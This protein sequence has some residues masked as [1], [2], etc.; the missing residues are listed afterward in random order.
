MNL[1]IVQAAQHRYDTALFSYRKALQYRTRYATCHYNIGNLYI[2][3]GK[4]ELAVREW[5]IAVDINPKHR[6]AWA[7]ILAYLD[8][9]GNT[10]QVLNVSHKA[11]RSIPND[12]AVLF[13]RANALGKLNRFVE[14]EIIYRQIIEI[15]PSYALYHV[16]LGV[17]YHRWNRKS[18]AIQAYRKALQIDS[19]LKSAK[20]NLQKLESKQQQQQ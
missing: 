19:S 16:N 8:N 7:N 12:T 15:K 11:L 9:S 5:Q 13:T 1:G 2:E 18:M 3:Q 20:T 14:A 4:N 10:E 17:L 6:K